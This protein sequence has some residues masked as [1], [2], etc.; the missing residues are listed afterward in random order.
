MLKLRSFSFCLLVLAALPAYA[1][2]DM[3]K[4]IC[5]NKIKPPIEASA[6]KDYHFMR[7]GDYVR[8]HAG[9]VDLPDIVLSA[10]GKIV[11]HCGGMPLPSGAPKEDPACTVACNPADACKGLR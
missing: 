5:A 7:C 6:F 8:G 3:L 11:A 9:G 4:A 2:D 1:E 10:K